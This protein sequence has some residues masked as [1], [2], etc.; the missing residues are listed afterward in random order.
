MSPETVQEWSGTTTECLAYDF[1]QL[2]HH[3]QPRVSRQPSH[4][5]EVPETVAQQDEIIR[6]IAES[7][8]AQ[9]DAEPEVEIDSDPT[10]SSDDDY[11]PI[12]QMAPLPHDR[13]ASTSGLAPLPPP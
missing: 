4:R 7:E 3:S 2:V 12:P 13:K 6:V 1:T 11:P 8:K 9:L 10:D 5:P